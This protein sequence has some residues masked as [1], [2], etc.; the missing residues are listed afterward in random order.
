MLIVALNRYRDIV[1]APESHEIDYD[2][3]DPGMTKPTFAAVRVNDLLET[4]TDRYKP[5]ASF[6]QKI[7]FIIGVQIEIF[8][9]YHQRLFDSLSKYQMSS[10][11]LGRTIQG[12]SQESAAEVSGLKGIEH[13]C[14]IYGS[15][16]YLEKKMRDWS[17][18]LFFIELY[19]ELQD[20]VRGNRPGKAVAG[21]MSIEA[22]AERTS[23]TV[24]PGSAQNEDEDNVTESGALFDETASAYR[25]L[26]IRTESILTEALT[27]SLRETLKAYG[28]INPWSSLSAESFPTST[29]SE[30]DPFLQTVQSNLSLLSKT[31]ARAPLRRI[32][33]Q[34][35][36]AI[37]AVFWDNVLMYH[38]FSSGGI[39]Q[40][41]RDVEVVWET[42]DRYLGSRQAVAGMRKLKDA[43]VLL[44]LPNEKRS[45]AA[46]AT[47]DANS[48]GGNA[49]D[50]D[51]DDDLTAWD[52]DEDADGDK[53][54]QTEETDADAGG[55]EASQDK[56]QPRTK[57][58]DT[59][60]DIGLG[61]W[62]VE[63]RVFRSNESAREVLEEL[64][65]D[66][67]TEMD[68]RKVMERII[69]VG[70]GGNG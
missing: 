58:G 57:R 29:S 15:A 28:R 55:D 69:E 1:N 50:A 43:M 64:G 70:D 63:K 35:C 4:I 61:L 11:S 8:D 26:R 3:V 14:R 34:I 47:T 27:A 41:I 66:A 45:G 12:D 25:S 16:E 39:S 46:A 33:R 38:T 18:D 7:Q 10:S 13:L 51:E 36:L 19:E 53:D 60:M 62:E 9:Q 49:T 22:V 5:L 42:L 23:S 17:D 32:G 40:F 65:L 67:L 30:L 6:S 24:A 48:F 68:A 54:I 56:V 37:Q 21:P 52:A 20:R 31:L 44:S 2:S 59:L